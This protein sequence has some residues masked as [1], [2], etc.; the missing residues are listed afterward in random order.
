MQ[1]RFRVCG[2]RA[3]RFCDSLGLDV[4]TLSLLIR[5][6][7][8]TTIELE[9][10]GLVASLVKEAWL[11]SHATPAEF[12]DHKNVADAL[13]L[14]TISSPDASQILFC[15]GG[16]YS[17]VSDLL[18]DRIEQRSRK[19]GLVSALTSDPNRRHLIHPSIP[20]QRFSMML[21]RSNSAQL[22]M[23]MEFMAALDQARQQELRLLRFEI[24]RI[25][26]IPLDAGRDRIP[27]R[28]LLRASFLSQR[29]ESGNVTY[30]PE[31]ESEV[32]AI[33]VDG[34]AKVHFHLVHS[35]HSW[36]GDC[37]GSILLKTYI[38]NESFGKRTSSPDVRLM[39]YF[40]A[41]SGAL[42][43]YQNFSSPTDLAICCIAWT[44]AACVMSEEFRR[45]GS[46]SVV[47]LP[48]T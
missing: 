28:E 8:R 29:C 30:S 7:S 9:Q 15:D 45:S 38:R 10:R 48:G 47:A 36:N 12:A 33:F 42:T 40:T 26:D 11:K 3:Q 35:P 24:D 44:S 14:E 27:V 19:F 1:S 13:M 6:A 43:P 17:Y 21:E 2:S 4:D 37:C 5:A 32:A 34:Q 20:E 41:L 39:F 31:S 18:R 16:T 22:A 25:H 46:D 23:Y